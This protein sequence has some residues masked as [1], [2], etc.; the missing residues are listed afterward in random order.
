MKRVWNEISIGSKKISPSRKSVITS[1]F[2]D[3]SD[4]MIDI[5]RKD[6]DLR[7]SLIEIRYDLFQERSVK[8]IDNLLAYL[9]EEG[10]DYVFT[11]RGSENYRKTVEH[12]SSLVAKH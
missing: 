7:R 6:R 4:S 1:V 12:I 10:V 8:D 2:A 9:R 11:Y 5:L 3:D